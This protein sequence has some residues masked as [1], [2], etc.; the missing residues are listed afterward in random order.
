MPMGV[1][2]VVLNSVPDCICTRSFSLRYENLDNGLRRG[3]GI[4]L[5]SVLIVLVCVGTIA[6]GCRPL[7]GACLDG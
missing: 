7:S 5:L 4:P 1:P 3:G 6:L 2:S